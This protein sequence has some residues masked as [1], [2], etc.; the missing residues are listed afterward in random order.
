MKDESLSSPDAKE[1]RALFP[2][3]KF[4][5]LGFAEVFRQIF[6]RSGSSCLDWLQRIP[7]ESIRLRFNA[8][9]PPQG[10]QPTVDIAVIFPLDFSERELGP[11]IAPHVNN[12]V[13]MPTT[14]ARLTFPRPHPDRKYFA[15]H[16][17][18][19]A[20]PFL[21][22]ILDGKT[23]WQREKK[24]ADVIFSRVLDEQPDVFL[25]NKLRSI[26]APV[27]LILS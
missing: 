10:S 27:A 11:N 19:E 6:R 4:G 2:D 3:P 18:L 26:A 13:T 8:E 24:N 20:V 25:R 14:R 5:L 15:Q 1:P 21:L 9:E 17:R 7:S 22:E 23:A 16:S 12:G